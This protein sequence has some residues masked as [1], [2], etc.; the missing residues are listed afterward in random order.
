MDILSLKRLMTGA[1]RSE[2]SAVRMCH[3]GEA[4]TAA[5]SASV[6]VAAYSRSNAVRNA[7]T[8]N[9]IYAPPLLSQR[10]IFELAAGAVRAA[11]EGDCLF[12]AHLSRRGLYGFHNLWVLRAAANVSR[13]SFRD[14]VI[15][16]ALV[17]L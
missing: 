5:Q 14:F 11:S 13:Q 10:R 8:L 12:A 1:R 2:F 7:S 4:T 15:R 9:A 16:W 3:S 17:S 6:R